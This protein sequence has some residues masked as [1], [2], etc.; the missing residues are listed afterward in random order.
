MPSESFI[1]N[2]HWLAGLEASYVSVAVGA[3]ASR[4]KHGLRSIQHD[5]TTRSH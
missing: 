3:D 5:I 2:K 1:R 4:Q